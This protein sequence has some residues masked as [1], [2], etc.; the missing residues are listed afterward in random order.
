M[1]ERRYLKKKIL[2]CGESD[3]KKFKRTFTI[4]KKLNEGASVI[5]YE[6]CH[7]N[8]GK[9]ILKEFYPQDAYSMER[10]REGQLISSGEFGDAGERFERA[11]KEYIEPYKMLL[12][13]KRNSEAQDLATFIPSFEI[14]YGC[15]EDCRIIGTVYVWTPEPELATFDRIC[16]EVHKHPTVEP[17]HKLVLI[18]SAME[19]LTKCICALHKADLIHR[20]IKPSN[21]GFIKRSGEILPQ[22]LSMFDINSVCSVYHVPEKTMGTEGYMEPESKYEPACNQT[23]IYSIGAT[24]FYAMIVPEETKEGNYLYQDAYYE[25][26]RELV[27][28][29]K[30]IRASERNSHPRLRYILTVILKKCLCERG[31]RYENCEELLDDLGTALYYALPSDIARRRRLGEQWVLTD[32]EKSLDKNREKNSTLA[33]QYHLYSNPLYRRSPEGE[34]SLN[35]LIIGFGNYG[36]KFLDICLQAGQIIGKTLH[37]TVVSDDATD[38]D[39]Y[40][41]ERPEMVHF[42][43]IDKA[44]DGG[45]DYYGTVVFET[46]ALSG[47]SQRKNALLLREIICECREKKEKNLPQYVFI[48]LGEDSL[49]F[50]AAKACR[51]AADGLGLACSVNFAWEGMHLTEELSDGLLPVYVWDDMKQS[52]LYP[53]IERMAFNAHLVW[54]KDLNLDDRAVRKN[55]RRRYNHDSCVANVLS[56]KYKLFSIGIDLDCCG[57]EEAARRFAQMGLSAGVKSRELRDQLIWLEHRRWVTE[58]ICSGWSRIRDLNECLTAGTKDERHRRHVCIV[59]SRPGQRLEAEYKNAAGYEKWDTASLEELGRLDDLDRMSVELHRLYAKRAGE[60]RKQNLLSGNTVAGIRTLIKDSGGAVAAFQEW[61]TCLK[62]IWHGDSDK[63]YLYRGLKTAFLEEADRLLPEN[64]KSVKAQ[65]KALEAM[66]YPILASAEY[67]DYKK[68]DTALIDNIPF[69]LTYSDSVCMVIP[70]AA[71]NHTEVFSNVASATVV[72][73]DRII[74][75]CYLE[76][77]QDLDGLKRTLPYIAEYMRRKRLRAAV[78]LIIAYREPAVPGMGGGLEQELRQLAGGR[79]KRLE[80]IRIE[81]KETPAGKLK[82]CLFR[83]RRGRRIFAVEMNGTKLSYLLQGA[84]FYDAFDCYWFDSSG[85]TFQSPVNFD[86][87]SYIRK[88]TYI[89]VSDIA[90][91]RRS[92]SGSGNQPEFF[93]DYKELWNQ[94]REKSGVWKQLCDLLGAYSRKNDV[95]AVFGKKSGGRNK[96]EEYRY[97]LPFVCHIAAGKI[98]NFLI[99]HGIAEQGSRV[100]GLTTDSCEVILKDKCECRKEYDKLFANLYALMIPDAVSMYLNTRSHEVSIT[101][102]DLIVRNVPVIG[103]RSCELFD[104]LN[105]LN[106]KG[107]VINL[108]TGNGAVSFTYATRQIKQ[109]LTSAGRILEIYTYHKVKELGQFDDIVSSCEIDW[110]NTQVKNEVDCILTLGFSTLFV[111]CKARQ[112]I[113]QDFYFKLAGL[114]AQFGINAKAVLIADTQEKSFYDS[115][116]TN[117]M[118]RKR[119]GMM[120]VITIWDRDEISNIDHTLLKVMKGTYKPKEWEAFHV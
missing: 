14:Y 20:D 75:L 64:R 10:N 50:S 39:L 80:P 45:E 104:L 37:V 76:K 25:N 93:E 47:D 87:F 73:P 52:A 44:S 23:D 58:K 69:M 101:F 28:R 3:D 110:E 90:A 2:L 118:Q 13:A 81:E 27:D 106:G 8:S 117:I 46:R 119:G 55:F 15:D 83:R 114:A 86:V 26:L 16:S 111:E 89:S 31:R 103:S 33:L 71:G 100:N 12:E 61:Y 41:T 49:N 116:A 78:E 67:R 66:F 36:Q 109:L 24:L 99:S 53:E 68:D 22:T 72:N 91:F 51:K 17:E 96:A 107:Y 60:V 98:L 95:I 54:E 113:E 88:K 62:E 7:G 11:E 57:F 30:L 1:G 70:Y 34:T 92:P 77:Q 102:D 108:E 6:A 115:T 5:C 9:G 79:I 38:K 105:F 29:S 112:E 40:L 84:G 35:V 21:F 82:E 18:L 94:Y 85:M 74:Y 19:S 42:F 65:V 48:A 120:D 56:L 63:V 97:I 32:A 4:I 43:N 59:K